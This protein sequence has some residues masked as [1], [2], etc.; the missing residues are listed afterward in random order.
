MNND[1]FWSAFLQ[2]IGIGMVPQSNSYN[3]GK[4]PPY[5]IFDSGSTQIF[6]PP[7][8]FESFIK[9]VLQAYGNPPYVV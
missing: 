5:V 2:G 9:T 1:F 6:V 3:F 7:S 8:L 4:Q